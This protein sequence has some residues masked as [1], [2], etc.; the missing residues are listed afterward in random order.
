MAEADPRIYQRRDVVTFRRTNE[1]FGGLSN[2]A[3]GFPV[4]ILD[5]RILTV[6]A[7]YQACRFPHMPEVQRLI[8]AQASPMTAKMRS[9]PYRKESRSDWDVV[10]VPIMKWC[11]RVK[12]IQNW[13]KFGDLL[14]GTGDRPIVED[15]R[16][17][18]FW[19]AMPNEDG[20]LRGR[21]VL[22]RLLMELREKLKTEPQSLE[23]LR[24]LPLPDFL[25]FS[26]PIPMLSRRTPDAIPSQG[27]LGAAPLLPLDHLSDPTWVTPG[28]PLSAETQPPVET[29]LPVKTQLGTESGLPADTSPATE[30]GTA[31]AASWTSRPS[32]R[33]TMLWVG[34]GVILIALALYLVAK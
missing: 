7:L 19:G 25:L 27:D 26:Q 14:L 9:K 23:L 5:V 30:M 2:M 24:P 1:L 18:D 21:N 28:P 13:V 17:D 16:K 32:S 6:E 29:P 8:I 31:Q 33:R 15:S 3:P 22:G 10:R 4:S 34:A 11:L 20:V 12:L